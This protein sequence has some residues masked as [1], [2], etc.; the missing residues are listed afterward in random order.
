ME[1]A[2]PDVETSGNVYFQTAL[3]HDPIVQETFSTFLTDDA[4]QMPYGKIKGLTPNKGQ[5][6]LFH[7][8]L[9]FLTEVRKRLPLGQQI[10]IVYAGASPGCSIHILDNLLE[11][12]EWIDKWI[13]YDTVPFDSRLLANKMRFECH[14]RYFTNEDAQ[15][16]SNWDQSEKPKLVFITD[17]RRS[18]D[19]KQND[20]K[21]Q[22]SR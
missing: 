14:S 22:Q 9:Q 3:T 21:I 17:I 1:R 18:P 6:K 11:G 12:P 13:L 2:T 20:K 10:H 4:K 16:L 15:E 7:E 5:R 19:L 8:K